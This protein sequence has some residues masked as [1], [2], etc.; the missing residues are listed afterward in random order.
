M[1]QFISV[2][3]GLATAPNVLIC[4]NALL[5]TTST[6]TTAV[7]VGS[8]KTYTFTVATGYGQLLLAAINNAILNPSGP[9]CVAVAV[10]TGTAIS[11]IAIA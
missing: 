1:A 5:G 4:T 7:I 9:T 3:T 6:A 11:A 2:A 10:P 8:G